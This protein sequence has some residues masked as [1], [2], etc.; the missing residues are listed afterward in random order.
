[1]KIAIAGDFSPRATLNEACKRLD[2]G[3]LSD[4]MPLVSDCKFK[5]VNFETTIETPDAKPIKKNGPSLKSCKESADVLKT[6]GFNILTMANN[7]IYDYGEVGLKHTVGIIEELGLPYVGVGENLNA[8]EQTLFVENE[9]ETL[10]IINCCEHEFSIATDKSAGA[11]PL[12]PIR[13]Y[14]AIK[15]AR[16]KADY[17]IVITHG[18]HEY[19]QLPSLRMQETYRFFIDAG[20]D[21]VVNHH[22]HCYSGYEVYNGK[23]IFYG[24]GNFCFDK[25]NINGPHTEWNDGFI[26]KL[27]LKKDSISYELIPY[28]Q[29][30]NKPQVKPLENRRDF[31]SSI[32][33]FNEIIAN[34]Q[35]LKS[36]VEEYYD[37]LSRG[38]MMVFQPSR[39]RFILSATYR[40]LLPLFLSQKH[41]IIYQN[42]IDCESHRDVILHAL[43]KFNI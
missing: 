30:L 17:V 40:N 27:D 19:F 10:A 13:Q 23:P 22:Q 35:N 38:R 25:R 32:E 42:N 15:E 9:G 4:I 20:A 26:V 33:K 21:T 14:Y 16:E 3:I 37:S 28:Q 24:I 8:A 7:H 29:C 1:M 39:N 34:P 18:G 12:N 31:D 41:S 11:N 2:K 6:A 36:K 5:I 43:K